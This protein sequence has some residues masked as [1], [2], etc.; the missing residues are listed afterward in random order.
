[1]IKMKAKLQLKVQKITKELQE[2]EV[3]N[4]RKQQLY[5]MI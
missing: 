4:S 5:E 1:M 3:K 2:I